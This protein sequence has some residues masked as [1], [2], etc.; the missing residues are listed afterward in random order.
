MSVV[1]GPSKLHIERANPVEDVGFALEHL[2]HD[3]ASYFGVYRWAIQGD[4]EELIKDSRC[5]SAKCLR[6]KS[7]RAKVSAV[8]DVGHDEFDQLGGKGERFHG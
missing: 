1:R 8:V 2:V 7:T 6:Q 5:C 4:A 3:L